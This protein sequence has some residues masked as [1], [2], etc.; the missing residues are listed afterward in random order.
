MYVWQ[1]T[2]I[3]VVKLYQTRSLRQNHMHTVYETMSGGYSAT[4][5]ALPN[6]LVL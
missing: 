6:F 5:A 3:L 4:A 1:V 2:L